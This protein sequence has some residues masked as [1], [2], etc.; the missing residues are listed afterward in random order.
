MEAV[1][2]GRKTVTAL[3]LVRMIH[4]I[5]PTGEK[6]SV[7]ETR[8]RY[9]IKADLQSLLVNK[10]KTS[11]EVVPDAEDENLVS[12]V[13]KHF[14]ENGCHALV[15]ELDFEAR[16]WVQQEIDVQ[17]AEDL[18]VQKTAS[19]A[20][21][22]NKADTAASREPLEISKN[23]DLSPDELLTLGAGALE[24]YD[25]DACEKFYSQAFKLS[26]GALP[27]AQ[28]LLEF[29]VDYL[30]AYEKAVG[31]RSS[32]S[33]ECLNDSII[34][35]KLALSLLRTGRVDDAEKLCKRLSLSSNNPAVFET[36]AMLEEIEQIRLDSLAPR[37][38][39]MEKLW[40]GGLYSEAYRMAQN[41]LENV[42]RHREAGII[43]RKFVEMERKKKF[44][45]LLDQADRARVDRNFDLEASLLKKA[46]EW[47][48]DKT[49]SGIKERLDSAAGAARELAGL[50]EIQRV[51]DSLQ[52]GELKQS[53]MSYTSLSPE[54]QHQCRERV[55]DDR[56]SW[57]DELKTA[58]PRIKSDRS[59]E[60]VLLLEKA[61]RMMERGEEP[62]GVLESVSRVE[63]EI[64]SINAGRVLMESIEDALQAVER[65][66]SENLLKEAV[67]FLEKRLLERARA[68]LDG[69]N[70]NLLGLGARKVLDD[71]S[72]SLMELER[73][74]SLERTHAGSLTRQDYFTARETARTLSRVLPEEQ[75]NE[76]Q[77]RADEH[78]KE[79][80]QQWRL[81]KG[82]AAGINPDFLN[83]DVTSWDSVNSSSCL[84]ADGRH[85]IMIS[86]CHLW[87]FIRLFDTAIQMF[88]Q[89]VMLRSPIPMDFPHLKL[90]GDKI[91]IFG[92]EG[93]IFSMTMEPLDILFWKD[94]GQWIKKEH[95]LEDSWF[96]PGQN[97]FWLNCRPLG[98]SSRERASVISL[99][100]HR[101]VR[102]VNIDGVP[103]IIHQGDES[104]LFDYIFDSDIIKMYGA[105]G[106]QKATFRKKAPG[107]FEK[108]VMH[109]DGSHIIFV[110]NNDEEVNFGSEREPNED[111]LSLEI[112]PHD[113]DLPEPMKIPGSQGEMSSDIAA[114][115][116]S[117]LFFVHYYCNPDI[118]DHRFLS[119]FKVQH[120]GFK[121]LYR[122]AVP[123]DFFFVTDETSQHVSGVMLTND[124][125]RSVFLNSEKPSF[126][127]FLAELEESCSCSTPEVDELMQCRRPT[128][129]PSLE[130]Q[131]YETTLE[132]AGIS[133]FRSIFKKFR[134]ASDPD[135][136]KVIA[137]YGALDFRHFYPEF[138]SK[139]KDWVFKTFPNHPR[140]RMYQAQKELQN[141]EWH[142]AVSLLEGINI[143][144]GKGVKN[145]RKEDAA[146]MP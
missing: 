143:K 37:V 86:A 73:N 83:M 126:E 120:D 125:I 53:L 106:G 10:F 43:R 54:Q 84:M 8:E 72:S 75:G 47:S 27:A 33:K 15:R 113:S 96:F 132:K 49:E 78:T 11:I 100:Q 18:K 12:L 67:D 17:K 48:C 26:H 127:P 13:L 19:R 64:R 112:L 97:Y 36:R 102:K 110:I 137:F 136:E 65:E 28:A 107:V 51:V 62:A 63:Q 55:E 117:G 105:N 103:C 122:V 134:N 35:A 88:D 108:G 58:M 41:I 60:A 32:L 22:E 1:L 46:L 124:G 141:Q 21:R 68:C 115:S 82:S 89:A 123:D 138:A 146:L 25:Y 29:F 79:I 114:F 135:P 2:S 40:Q 38:R 23:S 142:R 50:M 111:D 16:S 45:Q 31:L 91:W 98:L 34:T 130:Q 52:K 6:F 76:W 133:T 71:A 3:E 104:H 69:V 5:N 92:G 30:A 74:S 81:V 121:E 109:P 140:V 42:P 20:P 9:R 14:D 56:F 118:D 39:E 4:R 131:R 95:L 61:C 128:G 70:G 85:M 44:E 139:V 93:G 80:I 87:L 66:K 129:E 90:D 99:E 145:W 119:A 24:D 77:K 144:G 59:A 116:G 94:C 101:E 57:M 7:G